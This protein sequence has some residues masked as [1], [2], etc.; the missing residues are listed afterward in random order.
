MTSLVRVPRSQPV[1]PP[2]PWR[3]A[4]DPCT[5]WANA[6]RLRALLEG[7]LV[8]C[9][10]LGW[11]VFDP[12]RGWRSDTALAVK[13]AATLGASILGESA[14]VLDYASRLPMDMREKAEAKGLALLKHSRASESSKSIRAALGLAEGELAI[15]ADDVD[16]DRDLLGL[17]GGVL[18]LR[19][20][21]HRPHRSGTLTRPSFASRQRV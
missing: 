13:H 1:P 8:Y 10:G 18:D 7:R 14:A 15:H 19:E 2:E 3:P 4:A 11:L 12:T 5:D 21:T 20:V 6:N 17:P 9:R 16:A